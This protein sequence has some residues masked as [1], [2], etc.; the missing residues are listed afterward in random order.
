MN[1]EAKNLASDFKSKIED[2]RGHDKGHKPVGGVGLG[3][4]TLGH[5]F[6]Q[7]IKEREAALDQL[8]KDAKAGR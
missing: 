2:R 7:L 1:D 8:F 4:T 3:R 5:E 6:E